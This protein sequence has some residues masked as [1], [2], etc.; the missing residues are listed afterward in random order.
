MNNQQFA[1]R[2]AQIEVDPLERKDRQPE[3]VVSESEFANGDYST[4]RVD[5]TPTAPEIVWSMTAADRSYRTDSDTMH[6]NT[7][8]EFQWPVSNPWAGPY[9]P[10]PAPYEVR[11]FL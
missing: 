8:T 4:R 7:I 10:T 11:H 3:R 1:L 6:S 2:S 5:T 9:K